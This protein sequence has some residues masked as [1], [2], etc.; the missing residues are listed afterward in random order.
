MAGRHPES[1]L[2]AHNPLFEFPQFA[3]FRRGGADKTQ[4]RSRL[5]LNATGG[6]FLR[7]LAHLQL[8]L[9]TPVLR[10]SQMSV[11]CGTKPSVRSLCR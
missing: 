3:N 7:Q 2:Q 9:Q 6:L 10:F 8:Q 4:T 1:A 5:L 11:N